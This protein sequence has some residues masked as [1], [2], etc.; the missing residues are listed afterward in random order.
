MDYA[1]KLDMTLDEVAGNMDDDTQAQNTKLFKKAKDQIDLEYRCLDEPVPHSEPIDIP[2]AKKSKPM[3]FQQTRLMALMNTH[4]VCRECDL[5][6][7]K[8]IPEEV[9]DHLMM[10]QRLTHPQHPGKSVLDNPIFEQRSFNGVHRVHVNRRYAER[11][12]RDWYENA[13]ELS[14]QN[15]LGLFE[16]Q[17]WREI[18]IGEPS[19]LTYG[20]KG[21]GETKEKP[22]RR[23]PQYKIYV[24][25]ID[26]AIASVALVQRIAKAGAYYHGPKTHDET[27][28]LATPEPK[29]DQNYVDMDRIFPVLASIDRLWTGI[30]YRRKGY[31]TTLL[32]C[33]R[34]DFIHPMA[35]EK[36]QLAFS[37]PT[38]EGV[39]FATKYFTSVFLG[40]PF[41]V[42][43]EEIRYVVENGDLKDLLEVEPKLKKDL[44]SGSLIFRMSL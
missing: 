5:M 37:L 10:H 30:D 21:S 44:S 19:A 8:T 13:L 26:Y 12:E 18:F 6:Y 42:G 43:R 2:T 27:G 1:L 25:T 9:Q 35:L 24:Y 11:K 4:I 32:D 41:V 14:E 33:V 15:G 20:G 40:C 34:K 23:E 3:K 36:H 7:D 17:L 16:G 22:R 38:T 31:A 28:K 29:E 39:A